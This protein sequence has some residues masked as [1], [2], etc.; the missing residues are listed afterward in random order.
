MRKLAIILSALFLVSCSPKIIEK[1]HTEYV[2]QQVHHRDTVITKDSVY[3][4]EWMKGDT[5]YVREYRDRYVYRDRWRDSIQIKEVHDTTAVE[6]KVEKE[7]SWGQKA[8]INAFP[9]LALAVI[10]LVAWVTRKWWLRL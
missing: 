8:K 10:G 5:V 2:T 9:W 1:V 7:L 4:K 3:I 6:R